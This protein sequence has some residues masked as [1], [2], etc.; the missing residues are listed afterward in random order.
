M[1]LVFFVLLERRSWTYKL[2]ITVH[3][4]LLIFDILKQVLESTDHI[5]SCK[6]LSHADPSYTEIL[7]FLRKLKARYTWGEVRATNQYIGKCFTDVHGSYRTS[8]D[9]A[10]YWC[11]G[12]GDAS[13]R[14][15]KQVKRHALYRTELYLESKSGV[16]RILTGEDESLPIFSSNI[17]CNH[18]HIVI[19]QRTVFL[20]G[21][22]GFSN[23]SAWVV[24][25]YQYSSPVM[26]LYLVEVS[27]K[28][29]VVYIYV[30][31]TY[32]KYVLLD[33]PKIK[34]SLLQKRGTKDQLYEHIVL[35]TQLRLTLC[36][37]IE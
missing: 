7:E 18:D 5:N 9:D 19:S 21:F 36:L 20:F 3:R 34:E 26:L 28:D 31:L 14:R 27:L 11:N 30:H 35:V 6:P 33:P 4:S 25:I 13:R 15:N 8:F 16:L 29:D 12:D 2:F 22:S 17:H 37:W 32:S 1:D 24:Y 10:L 23:S